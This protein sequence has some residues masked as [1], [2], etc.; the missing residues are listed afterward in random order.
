MKF[1]L[2]IYNF[3]LFGN[4]SFS[5]NFPITFINGENKSGKST[6]IESIYVLKTGR[7]F[8]TNSLSNCIKKDEK[9]F[10]IIF[11]SIDQEK[12][13]YTDQGGKSYFVNENK[14]KQKYLNPSIYILYN[15]NLYNFIFY[16][17]F[18]RK[19]ID[20]LISIYDSKYFICYINYKKL[21]D[22]KKEIIYSNNLDFNS[23]LKLFE[24]IAENLAEYSEYIVKKREELLTQFNEFLADLSYFRM[25]YYSNFI[26]ND[27]KNILETFLKSFKSEYDQKRY[28]GPHNDYFLLFD[29]D[30]NLIE[31]GASS[32]F[33]KFYFFLFLFFINKNKSEKEL[34]PIILFDD[35]FLN[36]DLKSSQKL[37]SYFNENDTLI[38]SQHD[39]FEINGKEYFKINL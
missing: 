15:K 32:D 20:E 27:Y 21:T 5:F 10:T 2:D 6:V 3:R 8:R 12:F 22:K 39:F 11:N 29:K 23:K 31:N 28:I 17:D 14:E 4:R 26:G 18:R 25:K 33:Y 7:S 13:M 37:I 35:F 9:F 16:R 19:T 38:I 1:S 24:Q 36:L 34:Q 30:Y